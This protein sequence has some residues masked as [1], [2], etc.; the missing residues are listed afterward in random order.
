VTPGRALSTFASQ[1]A[2]ADGPEA[3]FWQP[4]HLRHVS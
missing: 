2:G 1:H 3:G 4:V